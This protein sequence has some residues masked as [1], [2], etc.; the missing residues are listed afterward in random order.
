[1]PV[2][3]RPELRLPVPLVRSAG[4]ASCDHLSQ[5]KTADRPDYYIR[6]EDIFM[7]RKILITKALSSLSE[8]C[9]LELLMPVQRLRHQRLKFRFIMQALQQRVSQEVGVAEEPSADAVPQHVQ[10]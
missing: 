1:M 4:Y 8:E 6:F 5:V 7:G 9:R 3:V 10:G 2:R